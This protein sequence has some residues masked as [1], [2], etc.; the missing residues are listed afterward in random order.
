MLPAEA[1]LDSHFQLVVILFMESAEN[2][3]VVSGEVLTRG[4]E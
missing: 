2:L 1:M 4:P 3:G